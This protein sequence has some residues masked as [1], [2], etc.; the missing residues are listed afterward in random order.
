LG[1]ITIGLGLAA[2][3]AGCGEPKYS[4]VWVVNSAL[5]GKSMG[6]EERG[7]T[8]EACELSVLNAGRTSSAGGM[9]TT[10]TVCVPDARALELEQEEKTRKLAAAAE[11]A[12]KSSAPKS[13]PKEEVPDAAAAQRTDDLLKRT[14][15][16]V[17]APQ[18]QGYPKTRLTVGTS[19]TTSNNREVIVD[20]RDVFFR[21]E[22]FAFV[23]EYGRAVYV[24]VELTAVEEQTQ[25]VVFRAFLRGDPGGTTAHSG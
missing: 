14:E 16:L 21:G 2:L 11:T 24:P 12:A 7:M 6:V 25:R 19:Y 5:S 15:N 22:K 18:G 4:R 20:E 17:A 10:G 13:Q 1:T 9:L 8:R 3:L 23:L